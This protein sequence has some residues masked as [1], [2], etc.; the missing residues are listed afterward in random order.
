MLHA[1]D[2][3][4]KAI[5]GAALWLVLPLSLLLFLQ[6]PLRDLLGKYSREANDLAQ[7]LFAV[8]VSMAITYATRQRAHL[9]ADSFARRYS[10]AAR[11]RLHRLSALLILIP[12]SVFILYAGSSSMWQSV[13]QLEGFP[14]T[15]NPGYW[16]VK[17]AAWLLAVLVLLQ[18]L[19]DTLLKRD[20][21]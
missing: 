15:F 11:E 1:L 5:T 6:W 16:L 20:A 3:T 4:L 9:A 12:W 17:L 19:L 21:S 7:I 13:A 8:Y 18:A 10:P 14:E 2:R